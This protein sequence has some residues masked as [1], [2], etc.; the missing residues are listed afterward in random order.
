MSQSTWTVGLL[1]AGFIADWHCTALASV[2]NTQIVAACDRD[3]SRA[4]DLARR[5]GI[6]GHFG[7][8]EAMLAGANPDV[9]HVLLPPEHHFAAAQ[10]VLAAGKHVLLE[11]PMCLKPEECATLGQ[12]AQRHGRAVGTSHNYL[13][14]PGY[15][16]LRNDVRQG[17][18]GRI[19][20]VT[21]TWQK[22]LGQ[23][24]GGP[25]STWMLAAPGNIMLEIGTHSV[26]L[27]FDLV[28]APD[29]LEAEANDC[30]ELPTGVRFC[31]RWLARA[32]H[33]NTCVDLRFAFG[34]G[35]TEHTI[36]V[37]GS[38]GS[39]TV[40]FER[41]TYVLRRQGPR[42]LD[43]DHYDAVVGEGRTLCH[44]AR[45]NLLRYGLSKLKLSRAGN[46]YRT[47]IARSLARFYEG[48]TG[49]PDARQSAEFAERV[50]ATCRHIADSAGLVVTENAVPPRPFP[51]P[52]RPATV[53]VLG[54][55]GFIGQA[56]VRKL[57]DA[58]HAVRLL[59][60]D[61]AKLPQALRGL[62]IDIRAGDLA[63]PA[64]L[65]Q[66]LA[67]IRHVYHLARCHG[68]T[69]DDYQRLDITPT[70]NVAQ[71]CLAHGVQR[72]Y[73]TGTIDSYYAGD[74]RVIDEQTP[75]D[76]RIGRRNVYARAKA[77]S[78][79]LLRDLHRTRG[80]P[81]VIFRPG[82]VIGSGCA[83]FHWGVGFWAAESVCRLWGDGD[84]AVPLVL[85]DD[86]AQALANAIDADDTIVGESFNL[87]GDPCL[88]AR[89]YVETLEQALGTKIDVRPRAPWRF[90]ALDLLKY[91]VKCLIR[92][93][94]RRLPSYRDWQTRSHRSR[95]DCSKAKRLLRWEP[96]RHRETVIREGILRPAQE[97]LA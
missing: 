36:H 94:D 42:S 83:P 53:L 88:T 71:A 44:Q 30:T 35:Y 96:I 33:G 46:A 86:V 1:G 60:R 95:F 37:R 68:K 63:R 64:D 4:A 27:L 74:G 76:P 48:L 16:R 15:E 54:G 10:R 56:L 18:L 89:E 39:A 49:T 11:K 2:P 58:G 51:Q 90:Y 62:P 50:T 85:V 81:V 21:I 9:V 7:D 92:H 5:H 70:R 13:F 82:V 61:P 17:L 72:L 41:N 8:L 75:L 20:H 79:H 29:R 57:A 93:P 59:V 55:S 24:Y 84:Q 31:R 34:K 40:D 77:E 38:A 43:F 69:W 80:L 78:E 26:A 3:A 22:E 28:G 32:Y 65:E 25:F 47:S 73:Y 45:V 66:A 91:G 12:L 14:F 23:L 97:W 52:S 87:V 6:A 67:R 19:D